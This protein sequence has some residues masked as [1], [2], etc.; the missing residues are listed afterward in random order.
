[1]FISDSFERNTGSH[2]SSNKPEDLVANGKT[3]SI[4]SLCLIGSDVCD[5]QFFS[6]RF[7]SSSSVIPAM[8]RKLTK[9]EMSITLI[10]F[11]AT[12]KPTLKNK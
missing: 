12:F 2:L 4:H 5:T 10:G 6:P 3:S 8:Q 1:M 11:L 9:S 7:S